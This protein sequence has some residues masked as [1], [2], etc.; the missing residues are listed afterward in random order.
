[1]FGPSGPALGEA[2]G[3]VQRL[4][5]QRDGGQA[6]ARAIAADD[7]P[8]ASAAVLHDAR[9]RWLALVPLAA[10][11]GDAGLLVLGRTG[12]HAFGADELAL[13]ETL[14][15][16]LAIQA[17]NARLLDE[18][19][20]RASELALLHEVG[21]V[22]SGHLELPAVLSAA[23]GHLG[24]VLGARNVFVMLLEDDRLRCVA[25][26]VDVPDELGLTLPLDQ[27]SAA[28]IAV[29]TRK[30]VVVDDA[31]HDQRIHRATAMRFGHRALLAVPLVARGEPV[32][33]IVLAETREGQRFRPSDVDL[34]AA[35]AHQLASAVVN[36]RLF[37]E[38]RRRVRELSLLTEIGRTIAATLDR[39]VQLQR[40]LDHVRA[41]LEFEAGSAWLVDPLGR[42][43]LAAR[44][45][46]PAEHE[47]LSELVLG[48][49]TASRAVSTAASVC[50]RS[51]D[52]AG[53]VF[54]CAVPLLGGEDRPVGVL[55]LARRKRAVTTAELQTLSAV[56][57]EVVLGLENARL[58]ADAQRR[59][60]EL[61]LLLD[62]G[63]MI[64]GSLELDRILEASAKTLARMIEASNTFIMLLDAKAREL[65][66]VTVSS[67]ELRES[68][69]SVRIH[70]DE[71][72]IA[73]RAVNTRAAVVV[74]D[75]ES[76]TEVNRRLVRRY[77][78]KSLLA[79]PLL[80]RDEPI[81]AVVIDDVNHLRTWT[82]PE[83][84]RATLITHQIAVAVA[85]AGLFEDLRRSYAEL[86]RTQ[87]ELVKRERLAALGELSAVVAHE[88]R[89]P[90]GVIFNSLGSLRRI[91]KPSGDAA[92]LLDIVGEEA[93]RLNRIVGDLLDFARPHEPSL[94][95]EPLGDIVRDVVD[96]AG[97][98]PAAT[99]VE[100]RTDV[101]DELPLVRA[102]ARMIRQALLNL[103]INGLQAM[104]KGGSLEL[105]VKPVRRGNQTMVQLDVS[106]SGPGIPAEFAERIFQPFFTT[107]ASG[108]GL[109]LAVVKRIIDAHRGEL[110]VQ[111]RPGGGTTFTLRLPLE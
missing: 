18:E 54:S 89:N 70:L 79:L 111:N 46:D 32:G 53:P 61:K 51:Q 105:T 15:P 52:E 69:R 109:G 1:M 41:G 81:G 87:E 63:S 6:K 67:P 91:L 107:K 35:L 31:D 73:A 59:V 102:D 90:L 100:V 86:A 84:E 24:R 16:Q 62:V 57:S 74:R 39:D 44:S 8:P 9:L 12:E 5:G 4:A 14:G 71:P 106:D 45:G 7:C 26:S 82:D 66:G 80:V 29:R 110:S 94:Q 96:A 104:P 37:E 42:L 75:A 58:F 47:R 38:E 19:R 34:T 76:S 33:A 36:A 25:S 98:D 11:G 10:R 64:T 101:A 22:I 23:T 30:P 65:R 28:A 43:R 72:S 88:V 68:F 83:I 93:D 40:C 21:A 60:G 56:A 97:S 20:R 2:V 95:P 108:T 13:A 50:S 78:E 103:V 55:T 77:G 99:G 48:E 49:A 3:E 27:P 92:M 17:E 85:N